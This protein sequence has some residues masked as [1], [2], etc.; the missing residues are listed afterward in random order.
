[1]VNLL[2]GGGRDVGREAEGGR[3]GRRRK[4]GT[5]EGKEVIIGIPTGVYAEKDCSH[6]SHHYTQDLIEVRKLRL[7]WRKK[8]Y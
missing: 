1:M 7:W 5:E 8:L 3:E 2:M 4:A 6:I